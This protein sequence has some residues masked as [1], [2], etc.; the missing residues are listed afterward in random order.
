LAAATL[1]VALLAVPSSAQEENISVEARGIRIVAVQ[2]IGE[3][4]EEEMDPMTPFMADEAGTTLALL[5]SKPDGGILDFDE[6]KSKLDAMTDDKGTKLVMP[7]AAEEDRPAVRFHF[8]PSESPFSSSPNI[9][10][11]GTACLIEVGGETLPA[12]D[13]ASVSA[14]GTLVLKTASTKETFKQEN[15]ALK[16]GSKVSAGKI[17]FE[18][19]E[20]GDPQWGEGA[21]E[22]TLTAKQDCSE[23][24]SIKFLDAGGNEIETSNGMSSHMEMMGSVEDERGFVFEH[25]TATATIAVTYWTDMKETRVPFDVTAGLGL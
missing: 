10:E 17:P 7:K 9:S 1:A 16:V 13:A 22:V 11:D 8:G 21:M 2:I 25:K 20:A 14:S 18:I 19:T 23:I 12:K 15:V 6:D 3:V 4:N 24:E 5:V